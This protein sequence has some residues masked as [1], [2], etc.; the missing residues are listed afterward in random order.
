M[1]A[2]W[3]PGL[4]AEIAY[5][6]EQVRAQFGR[7]HRRGGRLFGRRHA[8]VATDVAPADE[9]RPVRPAPVIPVQRTATDSSGRAGRTAAAPRRAA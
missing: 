2:P 7:P 8:V 5:R 9:I 6:H 3:G 4:D 1:T